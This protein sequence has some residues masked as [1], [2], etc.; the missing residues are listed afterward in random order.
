M[1]DLPM[2]L[3][4]YEYGYGDNNKNKITTHFNW[5]PTEKQWWINGFIPD[6]D[7][8]NPSK[9]R[10]NVDNMVTI[11][12]LDFSSAQ[13]PSMSQTTKDMYRELRLS[14]DLEYPDKNGICNKGD[15][16]IFNDDE[17]DY[18]VWVIWTGKKV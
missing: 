1:N 7:W 16:L 10:P 15:Y 2:T 9:P 17:D 4:L 13:N 11:G 18:T 14:E 5:A 3:N 12:M 6:L 8:A